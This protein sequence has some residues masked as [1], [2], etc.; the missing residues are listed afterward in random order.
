MPTEL[1]FTNQTGAI[2]QCNLAREL[3]RQIVRTERVAS[4]PHNTHNNNNKLLPIAPSQQSNQQQHQVDVQIGWERVDTGEP[5]ETTVYAD[6]SGGVSATSVLTQTPTTTNKNKRPLRYIRPSDGALIFE[7][8][9]A[10]DYRVDV[11]SGAYRC[12]ATSPSR[13]ASIV[14]NDMRV[15]AII[16]A[17]SHGNS[18]GAATGAPATA[19]TSATTVLI[20]V[21]DELVIAGNNAQ[22]KCQIGG[23]HANS[24][25][26]LGASSSSS[27]SLALR[28]M[29]YVY[30]WIESPTEHT[31]SAQT[32]TLSLHARAQLFSPSNAMSD[33]AVNNITKQQRYLVDPKTGDLHILDVDTSLSYRSYR[34]RC[35]HRLTG[36]LIGSQSRGK[37]IVTEARSP[38]APRLSISQTSAATGDALLPMSMMAPGNNGNEPAATINSYWHLSNSA[39]S[40]SG[41]LPAHEAGQLAL[42]SCPLQAYPRAQYTWYRKS[43]GAI[44]EQQQAQTDFEPLD[45]LQTTTSVFVQQ[46]QEQQQP[47][48]PSNKLMSTLLRQVQRKYAQIGNLLLIQQLQANDSTTYQCLA[49]NA[50]GEQRYDIDL[51]VRRKYSN[52]TFRFGGLLNQR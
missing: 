52:C 25:A 17:G 5:V 46:P 40:A 26:M 48:Q 1:V 44:G 23:S 11:H 8:F 45:L 16:Q 42:L 51:Q 13:G 4:D 2:V 24:I 12:T 30:D 41:L 28:Q 39:G 38:V 6:D 50:F 29:V 10:I 37:L 22:F 20:D 14:S 36:E 3:A 9:R 47:Q 18:L 33:E 34:C 15:G 27:S 31:F 35:R 19:T 32:T 49:R 43:P 7:P 21:L